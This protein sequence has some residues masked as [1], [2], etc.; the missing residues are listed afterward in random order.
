MTFR[1]LGA[2]LAFLSMVAAIGPLAAQE[3]Q[4]TTGATTAQPAAAPPPDTV[5]AVVNG[6]KV[7][8]ADVISSAQ[9]L[10]AEYQSKID[11]IFPALIDRLVDLT[12]LAEEGRK[13]NL[14][15][16]AEVKARIEQITNQVIQE[17]V[18]RRHLARAM[19]E[20]A[21]KARYERFVAEQPAQTEIRASHILVATEEEAKQIIKQLEGG[22]DFAAIAKE[23]SSDPSAKQ[24]GGDLG[25][26]TAGDMVPEFSKAVLAMEK[27]ESSKA[28]VKSQFGWHVIKVVD[29]R[30]KA[31]PTLEES[32]SHIEELLSS[33][34]LTAYLASLRSTAQV[35]KF[36]PD[37]TPIAAKPATGT[38]QQ[39]QPQQ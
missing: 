9:T 25:Y 15:D 6:K 19:T 38:G 39:P 28:P 2:L 31:P 14:Q 1:S 10:P 33:E 21:I 36:N 20:D 27:G 16:D 12:L 37:G 3:A 4:P 7:T 8:R 35:Q 13:Q 34:L 17:V 24:N 11:A 22:A 30:P 32:R 23:K 26:F 18:I 5:V 29:K